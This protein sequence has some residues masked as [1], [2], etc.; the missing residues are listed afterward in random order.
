M[1]LRRAEP[2]S[3]RPGLTT[4]VRYIAKRC[5]R[6]IPK[7]GKKKKPGTAVGAGAEDRGGA[8][9]PA[10]FAASLGS[11]SGGR[12]DALGNPTKNAGFP[13][14][15][16]VKRR[17][18]PRAELWSRLVQC[19]FVGAGPGVG[20]GLVPAITERTAQ[21]GSRGCGAAEKPVPTS[22]GEA[23]RRPAWSKRQLT[24]AVRP[25]GAAGIVIVVGAPAPILGAEPI[26]RIVPV[27]SL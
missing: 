15:Q 5:S 17:V 19:M 11:R 24:T 27:E 2:C 1:M 16:Q 22:A 21:V 9:T 13:L 14:S 23:P 7:L 4:T 20:R 8:Q 12:D 25:L 26:R 6:R 10:A 3:C 18:M